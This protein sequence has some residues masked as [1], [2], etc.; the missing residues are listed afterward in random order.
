M[1]PDVTPTGMSIDVNVLPRKKII[2]NIQQ[3][4][5][6]SEIQRV[7]IMGSNLMTLCNVTNVRK[8]R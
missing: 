1:N 5:K 7:P 8:I 3:A 2:E 4:Y 6:F